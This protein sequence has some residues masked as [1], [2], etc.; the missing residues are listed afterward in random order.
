MFETNQAVHPKETVRGIKFMLKNTCM[1]N[2]HSEKW[3]DQLHN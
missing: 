1:C 3:R 2:L